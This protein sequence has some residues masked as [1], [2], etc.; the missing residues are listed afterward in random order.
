[1]WSSPRLTLH[2]G[3]GAPKVDDAIGKQVREL[4]WRQMGQN[5]WLAFTTTVSGAILG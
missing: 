2:L 4:E 3:D 1:M 5:Y